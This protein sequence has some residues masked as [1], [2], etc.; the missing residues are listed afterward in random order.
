[1]KKAII[2]DNIVVNIVEADEAFVPPEGFVVRDLTSSDFVSVGYSYDPN[3]N[4]IVPP[5]LPLLEVFENRLSELKD[6][7]DL[8]I[9]GGVTLGN[10][11]V[12]TDN[13]T[14]QRLAAARTVARE[15]LDNSQTY[16]VDWKAGNGW[17][18]LDAATIILLADAVRAHIQACFSQEKTHYE[19]IKAYYD[20]DNKSAI[21][22]YDITTGWS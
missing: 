15:A 19:A 10:I 7:R 16:T 21:E 3:T 9:E 6:Y 8:K 4:N 5:E 2:K 13:L 12:T 17:F 18:T 11:S 20:A 1:M 14:Q 22:S